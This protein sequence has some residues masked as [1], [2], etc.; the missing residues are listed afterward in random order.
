MSDSTK[1]SVVAYTHAVRLLCVG[2][3]GTVVV[4]VAVD[5]AAAMLGIWAQGPETIAAREFIRK[6]ILY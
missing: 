3:R 5:A 2:W 1:V 4:V 6:L